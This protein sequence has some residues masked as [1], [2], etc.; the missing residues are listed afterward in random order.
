M[1]SVRLNHQFLMSVAVLR[2]L[3]CITFFVTCQGTFLIK[4]FSPLWAA[5]LSVRCRPSFDCL[6]CNTQNVTSQGTFKDFTFCTKEQAARCAICTNTGNILQY[7]DKMVNNAYYIGRRYIE[8][9]YLTTDSCNFPGRLNNANF[10][11]YFTFSRNNVIYI[12]YYTI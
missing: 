2:R 8:Y 6:H 10:V 9:R 12:K 3:Y 1:V 11:Q 7:I 5:V 4:F